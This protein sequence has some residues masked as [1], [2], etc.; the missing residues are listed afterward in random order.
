MTTEDAVMTTGAEYLL[1]AHPVGHGDNTPVAFHR[2]DQSKADPCRHGQIVQSPCV[3]VVAAVDSWRRPRLPVLPEVGS[4]MVSPGL[5]SLALSASSTILRAILSLMLPPVLKNSHFTT[6]QG[7]IFDFLAQFHLY[8][9][10]VLM[11]KPGLFGSQEISVTNRLKRW[12][13]VEII[14]AQK[15]NGEAFPK[16]SLN[17]RAV[18]FTWSLN[19]SVKT[20]VR[21]P[22]YRDLI[23]SWE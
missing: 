13:R 22:N 18:P 11:R 4:M 21:R 6:E 12:R 1:P 20:K 9:V 16:F 8:A 7:H 14:R 15:Q 5:S 19:E 10:M 17:L 2:G 23:H 3:T